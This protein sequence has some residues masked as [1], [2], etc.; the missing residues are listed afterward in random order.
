LN[1]KIFSFPIIT[2]PTE[3]I[4]FLLGGTVD[5]FDANLPPATIN[6][7]S[8][9]ATGAPVSTVPLLNVPIPTPLS[10]LIT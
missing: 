6:T 10:P 3:A 2:N 4:Q 9:S 8:I 7:G 5:Q 1:S